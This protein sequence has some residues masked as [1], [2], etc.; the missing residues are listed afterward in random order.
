MTASRTYVPVARS[1]YIVRNDTSEEI[2]SRQPSFGMKAGS[3]I[4]TGTRESTSLKGANPAIVRVVSTSDELAE[5]E[6]M[7]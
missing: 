1:A 7:E 5:V 2:S 4:V 6:Q 3:G